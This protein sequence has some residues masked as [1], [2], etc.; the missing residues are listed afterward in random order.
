M[1]SLANFLEP[2]LGGLS[3]WPETRNPHGADGVR[4]RPPGAPPGP[5][6]QITPGRQIRH[7]HRVERIYC[8]VGGDS[9]R[10]R[11]RGPV[12][13][14]TGSRLSASATRAPA[15]H[16]Q[17]RPSVQ[18]S[19]P[20]QPIPRMPRGGAQSSG[21]ATWVSSS[22]RDLTSPGR[23]ASAKG[24][25]VRTTGR[26][27]THPASTRRSPQETTPSRGAFAPNATGTVGVSNSLPGWTT[28]TTSVT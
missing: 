20:G 4:L 27:A 14:R 25:N 24:Y 13:R 7:R 8:M 9:R 5:Q 6:P 21:P 2:Q 18:D 1:I 23:P 28:S 22:G 11:C 17:T 16:F 26:D 3:R 19:P 12:D 10:T 15:H